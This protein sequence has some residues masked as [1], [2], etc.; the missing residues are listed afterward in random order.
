ME[1]NKHNTTDYI[2]VVPQ[3]VLFIIND[4]TYV[5]YVINNK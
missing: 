2:N 5:V 4:N 3:V 1:I